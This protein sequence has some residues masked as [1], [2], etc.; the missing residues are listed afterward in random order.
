MARFQSIL[1]ND[2][3]KQFEDLKYSCVVCFGEMTQAGANVVYQNVRKNMKKVFKS[4][5]SL[6]KGLKISRV[7]VTN[8]KDAV[9]TWIGFD[10]YD[11][12][13][14]KKYPKGVPIPLK[15]LARE[16]GTSNGETKKPFFRTSFKKNEIENAMLSA[17]DKYIKGD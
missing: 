3:I 11:D 5:K 4:T 1:P 8:D 7:Q 16:Y 10:G 15:V 9:Q 6:E 12:K 14:T 17:Q 13:P 2:L